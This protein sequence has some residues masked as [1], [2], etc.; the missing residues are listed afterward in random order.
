M[1]IPL[2][3]II[4]GS[5]YIQSAPA[6]DVPF[7]IPLLFGFHA[8]LPSSPLYY[9]PDTILS[10]LVAL[11]VVTT[12]PAYIAAQAIIAQREHGPIPEEIGAVKRSANQAQVDTIVTPAVPGTGTYTYTQA[13]VVITVASDP[14]IT[15]AQLRDAYVAQINANPT[16]AA[17][18]TAAPSGNNVTITAD[19]PGTPFT[20]A[21]GGTASVGAAAVS[22][23]TTTPNVNGATQLATIWAADK[24]WYN[25][26]P[27][28]STD[29]ALPDLDCTQIGAGIALTESISFL[30][31]SSVDIY[32][33]TKTTDPA[34]I[35]KNTTATSRAMVLYHA[36]ADNDE[37]AAAAYAGRIHG[38]DVSDYLTTA[39]NKKLSGITAQDLN[40][41]AFD[42]LVAK[43]AN[44]YQKITERATNLGG[45]TRN[46]YMAAN[47][48]WKQRIGVDYIGSRIRTLVWNLLDEV[49]NAGYDIVF[50]EAGMKMIAGAYRQAAQEMLD[51]GLVSALPT[52][53]VPSVDDMSSSDIAAGL[54]TGFQMSGTVAD[55]VIYAELNAYLTR[56]GS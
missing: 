4:S 31:S 18:I 53:I 44:I 33:A 55:S 56:A 3:H 14:A 17:L 1:A 35:L 10:D 12:D 48:T 40:G 30:Q 26:I 9:S 45:Y 20:A 54:A 46:G 49:S 23:S 29:F 25:L 52:V 22:I 50:D 28:D 51:I 8:S 16:L 15:Q 11:G 7:G 24:K 6:G 47:L 2:S 21:V 13:S 5:V 19:V 37:A 34:Y 38:Y 42:A 32:D 27:L 43:N 41:T 39:A 36:A